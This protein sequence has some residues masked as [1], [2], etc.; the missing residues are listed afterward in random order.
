MKL[1]RFGEKFSARTGIQVLMEDLGNALSGNSDMLMLGGG[2]PAHIPA[3]ESYFQRRMLE[4]AQ[5]PALLRKLIGVYDPPQGDMDFIRA[6]VGMLNRR[7]DWGLRPENVALTNGSQSAFFILFNMFGGEGTDG[8]S[9]QIKL[10]LTPEYIGYSEN[11]FSAQKPKLSLVGP[12][13]FK[14]GIDFD[15]LTLGQ[16][17]GAM[18]VSR[19][20][21]PSGNVLTDQEMAELA[22]RARQADIPLIVD[23]AY[24][25]PFPSLVY[26][27]AQAHWDDN[28][29]LSMSLS[30][31]GL[32]AA[33]TGIVIA[34]EDIVEALSRI[35][36]ILNLA[37]GSFGSVLATELARRDELI[38]LSETVV[39]PYYQS[40]AQRAEATL[41]AALGEL[42]YRLHVVE[43]A[44]FLWLW[45]EGLPISSEELYQRLKQ[46]GVLV[47][48][49]HY[50]FPG[51]S[52]E[53]KAGWR[54]CQECIRISYA[55]EDAK[56][57]Q[58]L[59]IIA[60]EVQEIYQLDNV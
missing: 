48:P 20:T 43:G 19:P 46:R 9:R 18:C 15:A 31:F 38:S 32:P 29:I 5:D 28:T 12:H 56:V 51:F 39:R 27:A 3:L 16:D 54:H 36:A 23:A 7:Y 47:V 33:R 17:I 59:K 34:R 60:R 14:Y 22:R 44:M 45:L 55:Q 52:A 13:H 49:G 30:K 41:C 37:T 26:T 11:L 50:F 4:I 25:I 24:G 21:N 10:P 58:G 2:N 35:N 8:I 57:E 42:P 6:L 53:E 1:T 40:K